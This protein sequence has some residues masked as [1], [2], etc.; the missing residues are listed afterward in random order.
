MSLGYIGYCCID[1]EYEQAI[2]YQYSGGC[3]SS[4]TNDSNVEKDYNGI[5]LIYKSLM[6]HA[7]AHDGF[8]NGEIEIM[9]ACKNKTYRSFISVDYIAYQLARHILQRARDDGEFPESEAFI[10]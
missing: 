2:I 3:W 7:E 1:I 9:R 8:N 5:L 6:N 4:P 10:Q